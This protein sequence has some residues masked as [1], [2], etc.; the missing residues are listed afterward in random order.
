MPLF[1]FAVIALIIWLLFSLIQR[2]RRLRNGRGQQQKISHAKETVQ[3]G[4]CGV[5]LAK[6]EAIT[7]GERYYCSPQHL[8][9]SED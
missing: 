2:F 1:R 4:T 6:E 5:H 9:K 7:A 3:C 8:P